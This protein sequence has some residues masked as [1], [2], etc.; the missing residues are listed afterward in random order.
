[1]AQ[2]TTGLAAEGTV[3]AT[4]QRASAAPPPSAAARL[5][6]GVA[7][8]FALSATDSP[9]LYA[10]TY[11]FRIDVP[12]GAEGLE[13]VLQSNDSA[14]DLDLF[15]RYGEDPAVVNGRVLADHYSTGLTGNE[16][17]VIM[18]AG[19]PAL[20]QGTYY[21]AVAQYTTGVD[22]RATVTATI[23]GASS[24]P[25][26]MTKFELH[27]GLEDAKAKAFELPRKGMAARNARGPDDVVKGS[28]T[29]PELVVKRKA[30][31]QVER[32]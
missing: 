12:A 23:L 7:A 2:F 18:P 26:A 22:A 5:V 10:G 29:G 16:R 4:V 17:I 6:S 21:I 20:R 25:A 11:G 15:A 3:T 1:L 28:L 14:G 27:R 30:R 32:Q 24:T 31:P 9:T 8:P 13:I 19:H